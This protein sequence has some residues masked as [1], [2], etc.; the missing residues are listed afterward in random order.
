LQPKRQI[1]D[2][3]FVMTVHMM[4]PSNALRHEEDHQRI[5]RTMCEMKFMIRGDMT[6]KKLRDK[7]FCPADFWCNLE[8]TEDASDTS[9]YFMVKTF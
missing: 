1:A 3:D 5:F 9:K 4:R 7:I 8:D 6:L 2:R